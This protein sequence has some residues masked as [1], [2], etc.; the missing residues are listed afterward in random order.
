[1]L[2]QPRPRSTRKKAPVQDKENISPGSLAPPPENGKYYGRVEFLRHLTKL[3]KAKHGTGQGAFI[4]EVLRKKYVPVSSQAL[5]KLANKFDIHMAN[6]G[7]FE[8]FDDAPWHCHKGPL[9][10]CPTLT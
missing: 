7:T 2:L 9:P 10:F 1:L 8:S 5:Y 6:G 4:Q 3:D